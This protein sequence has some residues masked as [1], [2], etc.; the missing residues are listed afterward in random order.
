MTKLWFFWIFLEVKVNP[1]ILYIHLFCVYK[2]LLMTKDM[3]GV[4]V[5]VHAKWQMLLVIFNSYISFSCRGWDLVADHL[6][7]LT[8][9]ALLSPH[10]VYFTVCMFVDGV[11]SLMS[12]LSGYFRMD[13]LENMGCGAGFFLAKILYL[14]VGISCCWFINILNFHV[15]VLR[16]H[17]SQTF[18]RLPF[19]IDVMFRKLQTHTPNSSPNVANDILPPKTSSQLPGGLVA[20]FLGCGVQHHGAEDL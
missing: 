14:L 12:L 19:S 8:R 17:F 4:C 16:V 20:H 18:L 15:S 10:P 9:F 6:W 7:W 13:S 3:R 11:V 1:F 2:I 5:R